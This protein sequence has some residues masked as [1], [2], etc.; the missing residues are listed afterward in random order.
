MLGFWLRWS[1]C[2]SHA[3]PLIT[4]HGLLIVTA[5]PAAERGLSH[6]GSVVGARGPSCPSVCGIFLEQ[7]WNLCPLLWEAGS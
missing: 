2:T 5:S 6:S 4:A 3:I 1:G 7:G